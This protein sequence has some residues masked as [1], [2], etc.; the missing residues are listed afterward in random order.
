MEKLVAYYRVSTSKQDKSG[1]GKA[2]QIEAV[3]TFARSVGATVTEEFEEVESGGKSDRPGLQNALNHCKL[4]GARLVIAKLDRLS[5]SVGFIARLQDSGVRFVACDMPEANEAMV[6][7][8]SVM[9]QAERRAIS[10]RTKAAL[11]AAKANGTILGNPKLAEARAAR[12]GD[13]TAAARKARISAA[14]NRAILVASM[15]ETAKEE[16]K[17]TLGEIANWL[18]EKGIKTARNSTWTRAAVSRVLIKST[19]NHKLT[20]HD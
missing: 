15:I 6:Q 7:M 11:K 20:Q 13:V 4:T 5:R 10:E 14:N 19:R 3:S 8:M 17:T 1:L 12:S 18:N 2:A 9:A 16:G